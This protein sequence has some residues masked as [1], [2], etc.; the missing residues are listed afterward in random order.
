MAE[1]FSNTQG[2]QLCL[3][4]IGQRT[5][6]SMQR[7]SQHKASK[8]AEFQLTSSLAIEDTLLSILL[9]L[10]MQADS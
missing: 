9:L 5:Q 1:A 4:L 3:S 8:T 2:R 6:K 7:I 10:A